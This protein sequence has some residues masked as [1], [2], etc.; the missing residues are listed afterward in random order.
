MDLAPFSQ[1]AT[2][3]ATSTKKGGFIW[4]S[5]SEAKEQA[6][7]EPHTIRCKARVAMP[8]P[9]VRRMVAKWDRWDSSGAGRE[10]LNLVG[11]SFPALLLDPWK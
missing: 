6:L 3:A 4:V 2:L 1:K 9:P 8:A 10:P 11:E 5:L 7:S